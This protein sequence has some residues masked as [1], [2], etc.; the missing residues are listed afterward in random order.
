MPLLDR[1]DATTTALVRE[2]LSLAV[3][4]LAREA[5]FYAAVLGGM[6][7]LEVADLGGPAG[8]RV[9]GSRVEL[10]VDPA[11]LMGL[12]E[13]VL[14]GLLEH[15]VL[16]VVLRHPARR[17][18]RDAIAAVA[19]T[20]RVFDL[21]NV[22]CDLAVNDLIARPL[23]PGGLLPRMFG[24]PGGLS[25]E[26]YYDALVDARDASSWELAVKSPLPGDGAA[27]DSHGSWGDS[28]GEDGSAGRGTRRT[29]S[30]RAGRARIGACGPRGAGACPPPPR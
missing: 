19:G 9:R 2:R 1:P 18:E 30:A 28:E 8:V 3:M 16:H 14:P 20:D 15:E 10:L 21:F 5:P 29:R 27:M 4:T 25:A 12:A 26:A 17:G 24:L 7:R 11:Q 23:P 22:A 6:R 13:G